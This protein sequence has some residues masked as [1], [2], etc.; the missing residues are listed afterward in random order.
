MSNVTTMSGVKT[1]NSFVD[2][3][4]LDRNRQRTVVFYGRVSTEHEANSLLLK[5]RFSGIPTKRNIIRTG[6][7]LISTLMRVSQELRRRK[8][9]L[10]SE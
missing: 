5:I 10:S 8:D 1:F 4:K 2:Y 7:S 6:T 9:L 3:T